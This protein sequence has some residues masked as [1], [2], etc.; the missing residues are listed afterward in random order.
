V[1]APAAKVLAAR[2]ADTPEGAPLTDRAMLP[3]KV[4]TTEPQV[5]DALEVLPRTRFM[6]DGLLARVQLG[7]DATTKV[8]PTL[9]DTPPPLPVI[10]SG[11]DP[12]FAVVPTLNVRM[13]EERAEVTP[14][15]VPAME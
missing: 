11:Y 10:V 15:G 4:P 12:A 13:P 5:S 2:L 1:V 8:S 3:V 14:D 7:G 9:C 6:L